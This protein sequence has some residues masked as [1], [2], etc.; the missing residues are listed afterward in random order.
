LT[1]KCSLSNHIRKP[2]TQTLARCPLTSAGTVACC[3]RG[4]NLILARVA[5]C[6]VGTAGRVD[7]VGVKARVTASA[8]AISGDTGPLEHVPSRAAAGGGVRA[9]QGRMARILIE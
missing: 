2:C 3:S 8:L 6:P 1:P 4:H 5:T 9:R 7:G